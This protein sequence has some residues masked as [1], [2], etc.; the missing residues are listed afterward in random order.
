M[1]FIKYKNIIKIE[2]TFILL[3][4]YYH[5]IIIVLSYYYHNIIYM[6]IYFIGIFLYQN[7]ELKLINKIYNISKISIFK[8]YSFYK[9]I[10]NYTRNNVQSCIQ[11]KFFT[12][13]EYWNNIK[14]IFN[15]FN[16]NNIYYCI[17]SGSIKYIKL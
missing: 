7:N 12:I 9:F 1:M 17:V 15:M 6:K 14:Y 11:S 2:K 4:Y 13:I 8:R 3:S 16:Y 5:T 10:N